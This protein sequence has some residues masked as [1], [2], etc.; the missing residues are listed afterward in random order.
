MVQTTT[1]TY[2]P[3]GP[4]SLS[5]STQK[6]GYRLNTSG[7]PTNTEWKDA[8][9]NW[10]AW[11]WASSSPAERQN[12]LGNSWQ[13]A[14]YGSPDP[15]DTIITDPISGA[16]KASISP[17]TM[18]A[19][20]TFANNYKGGDPE[21]DS[22][23][24][25]IAPQPG[26]YIEDPATTAARIQVEQWEKNFNRQLTNDE[27][28]NAIA[29][30][31]LALNRE[32]L[33][34]NIQQ[35]GLDRD[36]ANAR[37]KLA[38]DASIYGTQTG[39]LTDIYGTQGS[40]Y[41]AGLGYNS[42]IF[43]SQAGMYNNLL[44]SQT[45]IFDSLTKYQQAQDALRQ[46]GL[47]NAGNLGIAKQGLDDARVQNYISLKQ[48]PGDFV[49]AEYSAR[50]LQPPQG[51]TGP[52]YKDSVNIQE[53][54]NRLMNPQMGTAPTPPSWY[55]QT[56]V[57]PTPLPPPAQPTAPTLPP[58]PSTS[59]ATGGGSGT[60]GSQTPPPPK[61][62]TQPGGSFVTGTPGASSGGSFTPNIPGSTFVTGTPT[63]GTSGST[64]GTFKSFLPNVSTG[65]DPLKKLLSGQEGNTTPYTDMSG[66]VVMPFAQGGMTTEPRI[67]TGDVQTPGVPNPEIIDNPTG[68]PLGIDNAQTLQA[69]IQELQQ[70]L[71]MSQD[72]EEQQLLQEMI[73]HYTEMLMEVQQ[74][75]Q[76]MEGGMQTP[77]YANG[78]GWQLPATTVP[79]WSPGGNGSGYTS[80]AG[81]TMVQP[82][83]SGMP[84]GWTGPQ[85]NSSFAP[86]PVVGGGTTIA[87]LLPANQNT[88]SAPSPTGTGTP[89]TPKPIEPVTTQPVNTIAGGLPRGTPMVTEPWF[90]GGG[91]IVA[92]NAA[93]GWDPNV[94]AA[95]GIGVPQPFNTNASQALA[96]WWG[97]PHT[98]PPGYG[99]NL[100]QDV[101]ANPITTQ[102]IDKIS[103]PQTSINP[104]DIQHAPVI[105]INT[106]SQLMNPKEYFD[107]SLQ[108]PQPGEPRITTLP[109]SAYQNLPWLKYLQNQQANQD[110]FRRLATGNVQGAFGMQLPEAGSLNL[111]QI[112]E[113]MNNPVSAEMAQGAYQ[114]GNRD[115]PTIANLVRQRAPLGWGLYSSLIRTQ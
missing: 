106:G 6:P 58:P 54:I 112:L 43:G 22:Q 8:F 25:W 104:S 13:T 28:A 83:A 16:K 82:T 41:N 84:S 47:S 63:G 74:G 19:L 36:A 42:S 57:A 80:H 18:L 14:A 60:T 88:S 68:A 15:T 30:A 64:V 21:I 40:M 56:P 81:T 26:E 1:P 92:A 79:T 5:S 39:G 17:A 73:Q 49:G 77:R 87:G 24:P 76:G 113:L 95:N 62:P 78:T 89:I 7:L 72:P 46:S 27:R 53:I 102:P 109:D 110:D 51:Y 69:K 103:G 55:G 66:S 2:Q 99:S 20:T 10:A 45:N 38:A 34:A 98:L 3:S 61:P 75:H 91:N 59:I 86:P 32:T 50:A 31:E 29:E 111:K 37:A 94:L 52:L 33:N 85:P 11:K 23:M 4:A 90:A 107:N 100:P 35:A 97:V 114:S 67:M 44:G 96:Q 108:S 48:R 12:F 101:P 93:N 71:Q 9:V 105:P 65:E 115:L 70:Q